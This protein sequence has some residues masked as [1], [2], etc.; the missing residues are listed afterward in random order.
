MALSCLSCLDG[1]AVPSALVFL[2]EGCFSHHRSFLR[3]L[4]LIFVKVLAGLG[5]EIQVG[6]SASGQLSV[7]SPGFSPQRKPTHVM[8][9]VLLSLQLTLDQLGVRDTNPLHSQ[10]LMY[11]F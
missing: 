2:R 4:L 10:K 7:R 3:C 5:P 11:N 1:G 6:A 8:W 9:K